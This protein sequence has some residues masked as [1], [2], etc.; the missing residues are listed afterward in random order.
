VT[1]NP[2]T[3]A[4][5]KNPYKYN[6]KELESHFGLESYDY[7]ARTYDPQLGRWYSVDPKAEQMRRWSPYNYA[8]DN[9]I[10]FIDPDGMS[11]DDYYDN[12]GHY[13]GSDGE[14]ND[15][16]LIRKDDY[17]NTTNGGSAADHKD[18][19]RNQSRVITVQGDQQGFN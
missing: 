4:V 11:P 18:E 1:K 12:G 3:S 7:G 2:F 5:G 19:L 8:F 13:L 16:R 15:M 6:G 9:P 17:N 14:G 10:R